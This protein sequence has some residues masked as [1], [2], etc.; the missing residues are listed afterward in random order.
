MPNNNKLPEAPRVRSHE[1]VR[2]LFKAAGNKRAA[3][4]WAIKLGNGMY[5][6]CKPDGDTSMGFNAKKNVTT[7]ELLV[8]E[9]VE[10]KIA[11]MNLRYEEL[12]IE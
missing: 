6:R 5:K 2:I 9:P 7:E 1:Y 4:Y 3:W 11:T 8:G 12:E 10:E